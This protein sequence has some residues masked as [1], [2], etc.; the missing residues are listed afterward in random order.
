[1]GP[2]WEPIIGPSSFEKI[3]V[4]HGDAEHAK[5]YLFL[6]IPERGIL[7]K[8]C[9]QKRIAF[10]VIQQAIVLL[11]ALSAK[12]KINH[13]L[14]A[15]CA[16]AVCLFE[17]RTGNASQLE[18]EETMATER[19]IVMRVT[20]PTAWVKATRSDACKHCE[21]RGSCNVIGEGKE[22]EVEA[23]NEAGAQ[24]GDQIILTFETAPF[25]KAAFLLYVLPIIIMIIGAL[26]GKHM[27]AT[28]N[29]DESL[30]SMIFG[31]VFLALAVLF[32]RKKANALAKRKSYRPKI[33]RVI[34][35]PIEMNL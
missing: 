32:I 2:V 25:I 27:A 20:P 22:V 34:R 26:A 9:F 18:E 21:A 6:R 4:H 29:M 14:C 19:G 33:T 31:F 10:V 13:E 28:L 35:R 17:E 12:S 16:F 15:L 5:E 3:T 8:V 11:F 1:M 7:K 23:I 30:V 24:V